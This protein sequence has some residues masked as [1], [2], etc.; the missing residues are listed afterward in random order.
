MTDKPD[1]AKPFGY[2]PDHFHPDDTIAEDG[3][4]DDALVVCW[5]LTNSTQ[6]VLKAGGTTYDCWD[7][8]SNVLASLS[9][10]FGGIVAD[11]VVPTGDGFLL[12]FNL[13]RFADPLKHGQKRML[14]EA[15]PI[16]N[17]VIEYQDSRAHQRP[18]TDDRGVVH[19]NERITMH[20]PK[21]LDGRFGVARGIVRVH[22]CPSPRLGRWIAPVGEP[23]FM[24]SRLCSL[25]PDGGLLIEASVLP[26]GF[27]GDAK[28]PERLQP[29]REQVTPKGFLHPVTVWRLAPKA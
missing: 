13:H 4:F 8:Q 7:A 25:A 2:A 24:A 26:D 3:E 20:L 18:L 19:I 22:E 15:R 27:T 29:T 10:Y 5:D 16:V 17:G 14:K 21:M 12:V 9:G 1:E 28:P 11:V 6:A 23:L